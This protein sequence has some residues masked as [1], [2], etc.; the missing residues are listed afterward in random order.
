M[1]LAR[2]KFLNVAAGAVALTLWIAMAQTYPTQPITMNV[3]LA[4]GGLTDAVARIVA[5]GIRAPLGQA[6]I[7]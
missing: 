7:I 6:V 2:R 4:A 5:E 3:P 1:K